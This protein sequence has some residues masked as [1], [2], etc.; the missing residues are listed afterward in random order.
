MSAKIFISCGQNESDPRE[1]RI[2]ETVSKLVAGAGFEPYLA[3]KTQDGKSFRENI[4]KELNQSEYFLFIDLKREQI[5]RWPFQ[6]RGS[7]FCHQELAVA[8]FLELESAFFHEYGLIREGLGKYVQSN[9]IGF[10]AESELYEKIKICLKKWNHEWKNALSL[11]IDPK[12]PSIPNWTNNQK[13]KS[14][15]YHLLIHNNHKSKHAQNCAAYLESW[16]DLSNGQE[17]RPKTVE[18]H[19]AGCNLPS[20]IV[21]PKSDRPLDA[22]C[23]Y[24]NNDQQLIVPSFSTSTEFNPAVLGPGEYKLT[25][26]IISSNFPDI[27]R[28]FL[29]NF[30]GGLE[31]VKFVDENGA[32]ID[33]LIRKTAFKPTIKYTSTATS[34]HPN[35]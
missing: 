5:F 1:I 35:L 25:Y 22:F 3:I 30:A 12:T 23:I 20:I 15:W 2:A 6:R 31:G 14:A 28:A 33:L 34:S 19:W 24:E 17:T 18:L 26:R 16:I 10:R 8:S 7:L 21:L 27:K 9:S 4:F 29:L 32:G 13:L 11:T